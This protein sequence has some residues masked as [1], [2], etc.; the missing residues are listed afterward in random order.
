MLALMFD[1]CFKNML[2]VVMYLGW[3]NVDVLVAEYDVELLLPLLIEPTK[4]LIPSS[5]AKYE[6]LVTQVNYEDF[7]SPQ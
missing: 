1:P 3:Q 2:L 4:L 6:K 5:D 7:F